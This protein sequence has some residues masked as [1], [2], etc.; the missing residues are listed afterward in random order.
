MEKIFAK[1]TAIQN[2]Q[3]KVQQIGKRKT[4]IK[5]QVLKERLLIGGPPWKD[6]RGTLLFY[7][8]AKELNNRK[9]SPDPSQ[10]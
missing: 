1:G 7:K 8:Q 10:K 2:R 9:T 4:T 6:L 5:I 3:T